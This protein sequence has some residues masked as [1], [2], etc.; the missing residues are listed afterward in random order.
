MLFAFHLDVQAVVGKI[1]KYKI[2]LKHLDG[3]RPSFYEI[4]NYR[5]KA[6]SLIAGTP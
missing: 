1:R 2:V 6:N 3:F 4:P 5:R